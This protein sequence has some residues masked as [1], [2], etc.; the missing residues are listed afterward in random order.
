MFDLCD[1]YKHYPANNVYYVTAS[2][3]TVNMLEE[4]IPR[5]K[6]RLIKTE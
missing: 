3:K 6:H 5:T 4:P 1:I 2:G